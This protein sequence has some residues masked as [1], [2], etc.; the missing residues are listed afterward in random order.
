MRLG[1]ENVLEKLVVKY[2]PNK[3]TLKERSTEDFMNLCRVGYSLSWKLIT[4]YFLWS[5]SPF[6]WEGQLSVSG[7]RMCTVLVNRLEDSTCPVKM[8][9]GKLTALDMT[10]LVDWAVK[11]QHKQTRTSWGAYFM[12]IRY[13][14]FLYKKIYCC[15]SFQLPW[16]VEAIRMSTHNKFLRRQINVHCAHLGACAV[17]RS[18]NYMHDICW[19]GI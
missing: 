10:P 2:P 1:F 6:R 13:F 8:W 14:G 16:L 11:P 9:L 3:D 7:E 18:N 15:F 19:S 4:K 5:F 17:I 12:I